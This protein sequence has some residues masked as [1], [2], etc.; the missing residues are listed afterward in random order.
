VTA[1][2][3]IGMVQNRPDDAMPGSKSWTWEPEPGSKRSIHMKPN[4]P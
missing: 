2:A 4:V 3:G 1:L